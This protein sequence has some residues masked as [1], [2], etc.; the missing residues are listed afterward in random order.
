MTVAFVSTAGVF[1]SSIFSKTA[2]ATAATYGLLILMGVGSL[3]VL[4][5]PEGFSQRL[6]RDL[7]LLNPIA[8]AMDASGSASMQKYALVIPHLKIMGVLTLSMLAVSVVRVFQ[9]RR[10]E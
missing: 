1:F 3:M 2:A 4:L 8:A 5:D 7:F 6:V 10:P 9:L